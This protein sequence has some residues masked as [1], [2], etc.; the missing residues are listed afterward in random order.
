MKHLIIGYGEIG[1]AIDK[2]LGGVEHMDYMDDVSKADILHICFGYNSKFVDNVNKYIIQTGA[3][4]C[5]IHSTVDIGT[6]ERIGDIAVH[7][8]V[9]GVH[10]HLEKGIRTFVKYFGGT[11]ARMAANIFSKLGLKTKCFKDSRITEVGKMMSTTNYGWNLLFEKWL[12]EYCEDHDVDYNMVYNHF[13]LTYNAGYSKL[14]MGHVKR[15]LY[16]H[17]E[18]KLGGH[19]ILPN[20]EI[21]K[22]FEPAKI[23]LKKNRTL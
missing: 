4:L 12:H 17:M 19:C 10:P 8:P 14:G 11:H 23:I 3:K 7:S 13:G 20:C 9:R 18:G 1:K 6:T 22:D 2:V 16:L 5:I 15:P 21:L